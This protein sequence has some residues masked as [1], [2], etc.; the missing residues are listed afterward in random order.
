MTSVAGR[1]G[2]FAARS[3]R[4]GPQPVPKYSQ[5]E[6]R[7]RRRQGLSAPLDGRWSMRTELDTQITPLATRAAASPIPLTLSRSIEALVDAV[8]EFA[9]AI[10]ALLARADAEK[11]CAHV[12]IDQ[13]VRSITALVDLA[14]RP[15]RP[16]LTDADIESDNWGALAVGLADP[17]DSELSRLL[18]NAASSVVS[19]RVNAALRELDQAVTVFTNR[20][21]AD[22]RARRRA[23]EA[24]P[25]LNEA[26]RLRNELRANGVSI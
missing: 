18:G 22:E 4:S 10:A 3:S 24:K 21:D 15:R 5:A 6:L 20:L 17:Y 13:R 16:I 25:V 2:T 12:G 8:H 19:D 7:T 23:A 1:R 9:S 14:P 11:R 26:D